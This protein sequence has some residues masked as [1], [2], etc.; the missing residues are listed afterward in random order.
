MK[1]NTLFT[2]TLLAASLSLAGLAA[3]SHEVSHTES[4]KP[5]FFGGGRTQQET[6]VTKNAD[7]T[8]STE[9]SKQVT[10]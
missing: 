2:T 6:T 10:K 9:S 4:D 3:C 5:N 8:L 7:G 1:L